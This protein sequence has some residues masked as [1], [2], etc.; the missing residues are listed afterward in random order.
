MG[1]RPSQ[2]SQGSMVVVSAFTTG[3]GP[4]QYREQEHVLSL[5]PIT[6]C[7]KDH[8]SAFCT[9]PFL[10]CFH[11]STKLLVTTGTIQFKFNS[12]GTNES[13]R[14]IMKNLGSFTFM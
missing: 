1:T 14:T 7:Y 9:S 4:G 6:H 3:L 5:L 2:N 10:N 8:V 13:H 12:V 11:N